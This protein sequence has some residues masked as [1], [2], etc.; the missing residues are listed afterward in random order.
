VGAVKTITTR[1]NPIWSGLENVA[2]ATVGAG[3]AYAV[4]SAYNALA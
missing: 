2:I 4:G 1:K 3:L